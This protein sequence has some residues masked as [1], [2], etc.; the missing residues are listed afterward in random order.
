MSAGRSCRREAEEAPWSGASPACLD[1]IIF[2]SNRME[3]AK[4]IE[5]LP[6]A[7]RASVLPL[8]YTRSV[9]TIHGDTAAIGIM[10]P[11][12]MPPSWSLRIS[13]LK[14]QKWGLPPPLYWS[15]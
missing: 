12:S 7:W 1:P 14:S 8:N 11:R 5:P 4:G 13:L 2:G 9:T 3:R 10:E 15:P 6:E